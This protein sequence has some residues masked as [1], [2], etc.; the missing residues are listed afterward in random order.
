MPGSAR[1][2]FLAIVVDDGR[3]Y[4]LV[5]E[6]DG[7]WQLQQRRVVVAGRVVRKAYGPGFPAHFEVSA[8]AL[9]GHYCPPEPEPEPP[10]PPG[11][12]DTCTDPSRSLTG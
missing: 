4:E 8:F 11:P 9:K 5:G 2:P 10:W 6:T 12:T 3:V 7:L 1:F